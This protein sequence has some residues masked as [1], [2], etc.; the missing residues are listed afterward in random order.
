MSHSRPRFDCRRC[1][2]RRIVLHGSRADA[3][4]EPPLGTPAPTLHTQAESGHPSGAPSVPWAVRS[5]PIVTSACH[6]G[7]SLAVCRTSTKTEA[8]ECPSLTAEPGLRAFS[9]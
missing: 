3:R 7:E 2:L 8:P 6:H 1:G 4:P 9:A 5:R